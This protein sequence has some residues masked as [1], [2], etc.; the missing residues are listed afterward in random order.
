MH[1]RAGRGAQPCCQHTLLPNPLWLPP[2]S[3][4]WILQSQWSSETLEDTNKGSSLPFHRR[5]HLHVRVIQS[6]WLLKLQNRSESGNQAESPLNQCSAEERKAKNQLSPSYVNEFTDITSSSRMQ[7]PP[8][9][10]RQEIGQ[11][12]LVMRCGNGLSYIFC[13]T[14]HKS[15]KTCVLDCPAV[16]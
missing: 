1:Q 4:E 9:L 10:H 3:N 16:G 13:N 2:S 12:C 7:Q 6:T 8:A 14:T 15:Q 11:L 5:Q